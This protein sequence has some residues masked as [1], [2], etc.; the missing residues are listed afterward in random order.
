MS[1]GSLQVS[2]T[3]ALQGEV[4][5]PD[6]STTAFHCFIVD[7]EQDIRFLIAHTLTRV[8]VTFR[9]FTNARDAIEGLDCET[10]ALIFLDVSLEGSDAVE[11][12]RGLGQ[13]EYPGVVQVV[14]GQGPS[15]LADIRKIGERHGL[16]MRSPLAKPFT[17]A[18]IRMVIEEERAAD[19]AAQALLQPAL[20]A[21]VASKASGAASDLAKPRI[22]LK[23]ALRHGWV[24][25]WYQP[26][27]DLRTLA[28]VGA[29]GL[30]RVRHPEFG[31]LEPASFLLD[32]G[33]IEL[34]ILGGLALETALRDWPVFDAN[35]FNLRLAVN[36]SASSLDIL[37]VAPVI[38]QHGPH[39][40]KWP[41]LIMEVTEGEV[42]HDMARLHELATQMSLYRVGLSIDDF[43]E[44]F[45]SLAR[46]RDLPFTEL[47]L[48]R[49]FVQNCATDERNRSICQAAV[50][51]GHRLGATVV[52]EGIETTAAL[53]A[54][55]QMGCDLGQGF[56]FS[57]AV[58]RDQLIAWARAHKQKTG[59]V[60]AAR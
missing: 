52:A 31:M 19:V 48:D 25:L 40:E 8:G 24:E 5:Q 20:E 46:L 55:R 21:A 41:G 42:I 38:R 43:G 3:T 53:Q 49:N 2:R 26:K 33:E 51:L 6:Q 59:A 23:E 56:L 28:L 10:P 37:P 29:E 1:V 45:A 54:L 30:A 47:K 7:D 12:L 13:V 39:P 60:A 17:A 57:R 32:A 36:M 50:D 34:A 44:G 15:V 22:T 4:M 9:E 58:Q 18:A 11:A 27:L 14:S 35:G 16:R